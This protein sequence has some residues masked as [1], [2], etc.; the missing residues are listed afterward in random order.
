MSFLRNS[1][2]DFLSNWTHTVIPPTQS[3][4]T[5][6]QLLHFTAAEYLLFSTLDRWLF[7]NKTLTDASLKHLVWAVF[8]K[9]QWGEECEECALMFR[10]IPVPPTL[11]LK[12]TYFFLF[13]LVDMHKEL[14]LLHWEFCE[15]YN[16]MLKIAN[17]T[18]IPLDQLI[19]GINSICHWLQ[20]SDTYISL[21]FER[22]G[23]LKI[24][25]QN[26]LMGID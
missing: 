10:Q 23:F 3:I 25:N 11:L 5:A 14:L 7:V 13:K 2:S 24:L 26:V 9:Q 17:F 1:T 21:S 20:L 18:Q 12:I 6:F 19:V 8:G 22:N 15:D 16:R 4:I